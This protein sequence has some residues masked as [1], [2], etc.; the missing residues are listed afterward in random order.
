MAK[1][2]LEVIVKVLFAASK[3]TEYE[4]YLRLASQRQSSH[5]KT[6]L[7]E[8]SIATEIVGPV[9]VANSHDDSH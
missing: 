5:T 2:R 8:L 4:L 3:S 7:D 1:G 9:K 6:H